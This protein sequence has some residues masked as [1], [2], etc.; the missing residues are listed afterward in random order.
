MISALRPC[1]CRDSDD[2]IQ[3]AKP[4]MADSIFFTGLVSPACW[5]GS[6]WIGTARSGSLLRKSF[7]QPRCNKMLNASCGGT[8]LLHVVCPG[9]CQ[10][11]LNG[12][13]VLSGSGVGGSRLPVLGH[14]QLFE[15]TV[16]YD[17]Y[18]VNLAE[19]ENV[20]GIE[21]GRGWYGSFAASCAAV[22]PTQVE[23]SAAASG[24]A[25]PMV[26]L[27]YCWQAPA[28]QGSLGSPSIRAVLLLKGTPV[29]HESCVDLCKMPRRVATP[30]LTCS[31]ICNFIV[32]PL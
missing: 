10:V 2:P 26:C 5:G 11:T 30:M 13:P 22:R 7:R 32:Q 28:V 17:T 25:N 15:R 12:K 6:E 29:G 9:Y 23:C 20:I 4:G 31:P 27:P 1:G 8:A 3:H 19:A 16:L 21:L 18:V 24:H 14:Q